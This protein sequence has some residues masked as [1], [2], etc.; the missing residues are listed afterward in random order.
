MDRLLTING[1]SY[2]AAEFDVNFMC[3]MESQGIQFEDM[4]NKMFNTIRMYVAISMGVSPVEAGIAIT[5]HMKN[6]GSLED[7]SNVM[8][9]MMDESD[10]FRTESKSKEKTSQTRTRKK[11]TESDETEVTI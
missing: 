7:I 1:K 4:Q 10:F 8:S 2:K 9:E 6:G 11:K 5:D 3:D